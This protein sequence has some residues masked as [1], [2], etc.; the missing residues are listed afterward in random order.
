M[1]KDKQLHF[2]SD[3]ECMFETKNKS[4]NNSKQVPALKHYKY[5]DSF[6]AIIPTFLYVIILHTRSVNL[7][8]LR[9]K[10]LNKI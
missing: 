1:N 4:S 3:A 7:P 8:Y 6:S 10:K 5:R 9:Y 2:A